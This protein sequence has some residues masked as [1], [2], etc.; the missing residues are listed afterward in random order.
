[1]SE[2]LQYSTQEH[3][4][5]FSSYNTTHNMK[6]IQQISHK[7]TLLCSQNLHSL[8]PEYELFLILL[9]VQFADNM[10]KNSNNSNIS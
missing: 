5:S 2:Q 1:M 4:G 10:Q 9:F 7:F 3:N 8:W 6:P